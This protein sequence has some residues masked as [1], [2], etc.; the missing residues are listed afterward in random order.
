MIQAVLK[1][2]SLKKWQAASTGANAMKVWN[3]MTNFTTVRPEIFAGKS[4]GFHRTSLKE[5]K[6]FGS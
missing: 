2:E 3:D 1:F 5:K 6:I 4:R